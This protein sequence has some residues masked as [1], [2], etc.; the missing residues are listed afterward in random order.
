M[1]TLRTLEPRLLRRDFNKP[2]LDFKKPLLDF[3]RLRRDGKLPRP[4]RSGPKPWRRCVLSQRHMRPLVYFK[5]YQDSATA[6]DQLRRQLRVRVHR[7]AVSDI[8]SL[9][10][11]GMRVRAGRTRRRSLPRCKAS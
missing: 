10:T 1:W 2:M 8:A 6:T 3:N 11:I 4:E 9:L 5:R 7:L